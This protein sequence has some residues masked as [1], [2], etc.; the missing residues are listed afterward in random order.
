M[1]GP[2]V[3]VAGWLADAQGR[4]VATVWKNGVPQPLTDGAADGMASG[5]ALAGAD[6]Y[7]VGY[8]KEAAT[9][10]KVAMVWKNG[11]GTALSDGR[12]PASAWAVAVTAAGVCVAGAEVPANTHPV[13]VLWRDGRATRLSDGT[14]AAMASGVAWAGKDVYVTGSDGHVARLWKNGATQAPLAAAPGTAHATGL[15]VAGGDILVTGWLDNAAML[16]RNGRPTRLP[17]P[18]QSASAWAVAVAGAEVVVVGEAM[19][20]KSGQ[21][22]VWRNG[23]GTAL[24]GSENGRACAVVLVPNR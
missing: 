14:R 22:E 5:L 13:A 20:V 7:V 21:A 24:A 10:T 3:Y 15:A 16:W 6:V 12:V 11:T 1:A 18:A 9:G 17:C 23:V 4:A 8:R 19:G 2:D